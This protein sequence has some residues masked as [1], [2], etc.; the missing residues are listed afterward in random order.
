MKIREPIRLVI[1]YSDRLAIK[2][3]QTLLHLSMAYHG[4]SKKETK[5]Q[6]KY[7]RYLE[8]QKISF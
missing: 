8:L 5:Q 3:G 6:L 4:F 7:L 1:M 2:T